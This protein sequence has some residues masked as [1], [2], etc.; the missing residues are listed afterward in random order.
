M[1]C[2]ICDVELSEAEI[3]LDEEGKSEPCTTCLN[4][5]MNTAYCN[6]FTPGKDTTLPLP[7]GE[8]DVELIEIVE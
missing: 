2:Y 6:G 7:D 3:Q 1:R 5:I 8:E 4:I